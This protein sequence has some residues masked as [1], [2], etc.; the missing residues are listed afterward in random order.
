MI[1]YTRLVNPLR[2]FIVHHIL[3][4]AESYLGSFT[5]WLTPN[6]YSSD[7]IVRKYHRLDG[8][9][10]ATEQEADTIIT[11]LM[12]VVCGHDDPS[13]H[14]YAQCPREGHIGSRILTADPEDCTH[15]SREIE[16]TACG[17]FL[18]REKV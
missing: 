8:M 1:S 3:Y 16:C 9:F 12:E 14:P 4:P 13:V 5:W 6:K 2:R 17:D 15:P 7:N 11:K 10:H 18:G